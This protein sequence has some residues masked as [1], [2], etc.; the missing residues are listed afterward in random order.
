[1]MCSLAYVTLVMKNDKYIAGAL[2]LAQS[3][4]NSGTKCTLICMTTCDISSKSIKILKKLYDFVL[5]VPYIRHK[6]IALKNQRQRDLYEE[7]IEESFTK[8]N[9]LNPQLYRGSDLMFDKIVFIDAD[10]L[11][12][13]NCDEHLF[14]LEPPAM[15]FSLPWAK[16]YC[17][18]GIENPY[19]ELSHGVRLSCKLVEKGLESFVGIASLVLIRPD[20]KVYKRMLRLLNQTFFFGSRK[21]MSGFDEQLICNTY[22]SLNQSFQHIHQCY[23]WCAGKDEWLS[24]AEPEYKR[25]RII[26][27]YGDD[28]PWFSSRNSQWEDT[29]RWWD[30]AD[31]IIAKDDSTRKFFELRF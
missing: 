23:N 14:S 26:H 31:Q 8:W 7:W 19:G 13:D 29:I 5:P 15:T 16:P 9:C 22:C 18:H 27:Y 11:V 12:I 1:M 4:R 3:L 6:C 20:P 17:P 2:V 21:C 28:K 30:I 25:P 24:I 10:M